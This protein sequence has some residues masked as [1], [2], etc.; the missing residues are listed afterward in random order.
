MAYDN[1]QSE[2][3]LPTGKQEET[4]KASKFLPRY[5]RTVANEKFVSS[6]LDQLISSGTV[7]KINGYI[8]R[9]DAKAYKSTD[10]YINDISDLRQ[11]Y[12][13]EP[14]V[15]IDD[16][17]GNTKFYKDYQDFVN[18]TKV[19]GGNTNDH[20][21]LNSQEYYAWDPHVDWDK[22]SNYREYYWLPEGP[23]TLTV[24]GQAK[25]ITSTYKVTVADQGD[26]MAFIFT[27]D[28]KTANPTLKLSSIQIFL[29]SGPL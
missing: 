10:S 8:G 29:P 15:V 25:G 26:N 6:T 23:Q 22:F 27:P 20:S 9:R 1:N 13:L 28:G 2:N 21:K 11:N 19:F 16:N 24:L 3:P 7:E 17:I 5:F 12:Q 4:R 18:Q 14:A